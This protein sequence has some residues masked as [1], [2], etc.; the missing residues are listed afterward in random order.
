[1][2]FKNKVTTAVAFAVAVV[3][4][5][6]ILALYREAVPPSIEVYNTETG[7]VYCAFPAPEGTEFSVS[8]IH[9]VNKSP[10]T[11]FFVIH[12]E[13]IV[14]DRT[15]YS[16]FGAG[17]QTTLEEGETLS[18]DEDGNMVVSG[19]NSVFPEVKYIVGT[20]YDHVLTIRGREYSLTEMCGRNAHIAIA[21]R[22]PKWKLRRETASKEE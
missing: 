15:V 8:F 6:I 22:V 11:D 13:Q 14:A 5:I 10:V 20:V 3:L 4:F 2:I 16:S 1:M 7:R 19:F 21:L 12:D 9:S 17:V 18:Y